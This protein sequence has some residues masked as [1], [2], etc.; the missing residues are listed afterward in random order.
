MTQ[1]RF[2]E[3]VR[4]E[5]EV[6]RRFLLALCGGCREEAEDL[7]QETLIKAWLASEQY[8]ERYRF[9]T[10]LCKI[11]YRTYID[12]LRRNLNT[13]LPLD[14]NIVLPASERTDGAFQY[15]HLYRAIARLP[16]KER[17]AVLLFY[18]EGQSIREIATATGSS[19]LS[20]KK[21]L[22]RGRK[23]LRKL[24]TI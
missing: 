7:A 8:V 23:N 13:P 6:L 18:I 14:D 19:T 22:E 15:E 10:W 9:S 3:L 1:E 20:V 12:Y 24:L 11:A 5:Q 2:T 17:M 16:L 21:Q 4:E